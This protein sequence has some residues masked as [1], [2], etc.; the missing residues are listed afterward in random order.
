MSEELKQRK[1]VERRFPFGA[2]CFSECNVYNS[3]S[4][5]D[6]DTNFLQHKSADDKANQ[7]V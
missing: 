1:V 6:L 3:K 2:Q 4:L 7:N 5:I